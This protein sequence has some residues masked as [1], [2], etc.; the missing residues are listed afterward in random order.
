MNR[1][2]RPAP[3]GTLTILLTDVEGSTKLWEE[4]AESMRAA[5]GRHHKLVLGAIER[6]GGY[7]PP[8]QGEGDSV[9]AVFSDASVALGCVLELQRS[10]AT[11]AWPPGADL[12]VRAAL[13]SGS[14]DL[15]DERNYAGPTLNRGARLRAI[16]HGG[17]T[18]LSDATRALV[19]SALPPD[20]TLRDLGMHRLKDLSVPERVFQLCH[21]ELIVDFAALRSLDA[22]PHNLPVQLTRF[23]G[24][25]GEIVEVCALLAHNRL[26]TLAGAGGCGKTRLALQVAAHVL[27]EYPDGVWLAEL[28]AVSDAEVVPRTVAAA[29]RVREEQGRP[30]AD[31]L[32]DHLAPTTTLLVLDNCEHVIAAA[33]GLVERLLTACPRLT[34]LATSREPLAL[35]GEGLWTVHP[36]ST[37]DPGERATLEQLGESESI[38]LFLDRATSS[39]PS[40]ALTDPNAASVAAICRRLEG[41]PLA[42]ELAAARLR[43]LSVVQIEELLGDRFRLLGQGSRTA[44]PQHRALRA[45]LD[46]SHDLLSEPERIVFRRLSGFAGGFTLAAAEAVCAGSGIE[47][48]EVLDLVSQL[49]LK[50]LALSHRDVGSARYRMLETMR[51][52]SLEKLQEAGEE[53][54]IRD[55]QLAWA[56]GLA[57]HAEPALEG[58]EQAACL[59][60]LYAELDNFRNA[61]AWSVITEEAELSLRLG[62]ALHEFW[63]VRADWSEG[64]DW[65]ERALVLPGQ[66]DP[67]VRMKALYAAGVLADALSDY[68]ASDEC[69]GESLAIAR[70]IDDRRGIAVAL[71]GLAQEAERVGEHARARP[72]LQESVAILRDL[73]DEPSLA[74]SLGGLAW[75]ENDYRK[76][77]KLWTAELAIRRRLANRESVGWTVLM[78]GACAQGEGDYPAARASYRECLE[79]ARELGYKRMIAR[80]LTQFGE[81]ALLEGDLAEARKVLEESVP[82]WR[83]T[84][85]QSGLVDGLR[86]L[87][88]VARMERKLDEALVLLSESLSISR[89]VGSRPME[90]RAL[91]SLAVHAIYGGNLTQAQ[92]YLANALALWR[93]MD[94]IAGTSAALRRLGEITAARGELERAARLLG[95]AEALRESVGAA[96][97][98]A[99]R[100]S[101]EEAVA[102]ARLGLGERT[103][104]SAWAAGRK[105]DVFGIEDLGIAARA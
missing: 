31:T 71:M 56:V 35:R 41:I 32:A 90:A 91:Q 30:I 3:T 40:F 50:S 89:E 29:V 63:V 95:T 74:R 20:T 82:L 94:D 12:R 84:R 45:T 10:L 96:I 92:G 97:G 78:V 53:G 11:E 7:R 70:A 48:E 55:S 34:V 58:P 80:A 37:P 36:L 64:R 44:L 39:D 69:F 85:H 104:A 79:I 25:E 72:L 62:S 6:H 65:L 99:E 100:E 2:G 42:L 8:D 15:R 73:G 38:Q 98:P 4:H 68:S 93:R 51:E 60:R 54:A 61:F 5:I 43:T 103:F 19:G 66:V 1:Y 57:E 23:I 52:F 105:I 75:L 49:V 33:A 9:F 13:H 17:Q 86:A 22:R 83:E 59:E 26:L 47:R 27:D 18:V 88:D 77:R 67:V 28:A 24:R 16:A 87:G 14:L 81:V 101:Y 21:P 46:W 76:A 102:D